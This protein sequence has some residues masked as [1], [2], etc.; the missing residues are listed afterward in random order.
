MDCLLQFLYQLNLASKQMYIFE[1]WRCQFHEL[2]MSHLFQFV[3]I[4]LCIMFLHMLLVHFQIINSDFPFYFQY[5]SF[6]YY[7]MK[8]VKKHYLLKYRKMRQLV[9]TVLSQ[10]TNHNTEQ[11]FQ[12]NHIN[13]CMECMVFLVNSRKQ[14][15]LF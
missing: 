14:K 9:I 7:L 2:Y 10:Q 8:A 5:I 12:T 4:M 13:E 6:T 3:C 15:K 11:F 1:I